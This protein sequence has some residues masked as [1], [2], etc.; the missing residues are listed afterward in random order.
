MNELDLTCKIIVLNILWYANDVALTNAQVAEFF[1]DN[2]IVNYFSVQDAIG[3]LI[4]T[5]NIDVIR[6]ANQ[7]FYRINAK[8]SETLSLFTDRITTRMRERI[9]TY[10]KANEVTIREENSLIGDYYES[11]SGYVCHLKKIQAHAALIDIS[12]HVWDKAQAE[13]ICANWKV[14]ADE[15]YD[16]LLDILVN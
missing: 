3:S 16:T 7:V 13:A 5:G 10:L 15:V 6:S 8:G 1:L 4:E 14:A 2:R 11:D 12:F 9:L